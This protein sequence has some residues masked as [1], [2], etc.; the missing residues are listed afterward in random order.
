[1]LAL[2][3]AGALAGI[4]ARAAAP[5]VV[6]YASDVT[7]TH[8]GW[9]LAAD[10]SAAGGQMMT[11]ALSAATATSAPLAAP[12]DYFEATFNASAATPYHVWIRLRAT[13]NSKWSD[14]LWAQ[15]SDATTASGAAVY[16]IGTTSGLLVNLATDSTGASDV[17][18]GWQDGAYW[19]TQLSVLQFATSGAHTIRVQTREAG[20]QVDQIVLSPSTYLTQSPGQVSG[21]TTIVPKP[22]TGAPP[23]SGLSPYSGTPASVPG[24]IQAAN[25]DNGGEGVAY[26]DTTPGNTG[27]AYRQ[28]DVDIQSSS[29]GGLNIGW[30]APGE[31]LNYTVN[32]SAAASY[33][34]QLRV[35]SLGG[36]TLHV[37]FNGPSSGVWQSVSIP[38]SGGWQSWTTVN[39]PVSLRAG[40]QQLTILFDTGWVNLESIAVV[41]AGSGGGTPPPGVPHFSHAYVIVLE[42]QELS[43]IIGNP[44]APYINQLASQY[45]LATAYAAVTHPSLPNYM[46][47]TGGDTFFTSDCV[48]C[49]VDAPNISDELETAGITW[50]AYMESMPAACGTTDTSLYATKHNPF[51]HYDD[52]V[53]NQPRCQSHVVPWSTWNT[54][55]SA[56]TLPTFAW[57]TPNLCSDMHDC[58]VTTGD[59]WL[60]QVVPQILAT[61]DFGNS[62]LFIVWDEGTTNVGGGG[63]VP[64]LVVSPLVSP[65]FTSSIPATHFDLL[66]TLEDAW[67][68]AP[69]G[70]SA[71]ARDLDEFFQR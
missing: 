45:G 33:T 49:T 39:V 30:T 37:G 54:D 65:G 44:A 68:L 27:G 66:R 21:D 25:F 61:P 22:G 35:A 12:A 24:T 64:L 26:H 53:S 36:A 62:V 28:T 38:D 63:L 43:G 56:R 9:S 60:S 52:I 18:W 32:V 29:E 57:I 41:A 58:D 40:V 1:V 34:V 11:S 23:S 50:K 71:G 15:F 19:L 14:S 59:T 67:G 31:W 70:R 8:G 2:F 51:I 55:V 46:A 3:T 10:S 47:L 13:S 42:N 6:L 17:G 20:V 4:R 69:L 16:G 5:D 48:G 7:T